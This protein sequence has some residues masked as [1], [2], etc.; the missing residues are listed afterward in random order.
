MSDDY[1]KESIE[2]PLSLLEVV[3]DLQLTLNSIECL[4]SYIP[5]DH[6]IHPLL[7]DIQISGRRRFDNALAFC[8]THG[9]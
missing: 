9:R 7:T 3:F 5:E 1:S 2:E 4:L 8:V 6:D